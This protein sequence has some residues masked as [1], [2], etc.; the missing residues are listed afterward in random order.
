MLQSKIELNKLGDLPDSEMRLS[1]LFITLSSALDMGSY[2]LLDHSQRVAYIALEIAKVL[3]LGSEDINKLLLAALI[4]DIGIV[5]H[6]NKERAQNLF[7]VELGLAESHCKLGAELTQKLTFIPELAEII[8]YH[9]HKWDG[10]NFDQL[11]KN[12]IPL[13]SRIIHLADRIEAYID[14]DVFILNQVENIIRAVKSKS[15]SWFDPELTRAFSIIAQKESFWLNLKVKEYKNILTKWGKKTKVSINLSNLE[16]MASIVAHLIDRVS[17][18]TSR[19]SS[20]VAT[21][22]AMITNELGYSLREQRAI[23]IAGLFH[24]LGKLIVPNKIIEKK[25]ELT[26]S[27]FKVVKQ[28]TFYTY[29]LL[30]KIKGLGSIPEWA[31]FHHERLDG[32][33]YPFRIKGDG[34]N[35]GS[36]IMAVS[37]VFQA[38]TEDRPY[39]P[40]FSISKALSIIDEMQQKAKLDGEIISVLKNAI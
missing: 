31:A 24:D 16:S 34:L 4:H 38:L 39:R 14:P 28:H 5:D 33:G 9:H 40:A 29:Q 10:K 3:E 27:E 30:N 15:A 36:R 13:A 35:T 26:T 8:Y 22:A 37:D 23:R 21:I 7:Q 6:E 18:F 17:P 25:E 2:K 20:G 32:T 1:E 11:K 19:H 12:K